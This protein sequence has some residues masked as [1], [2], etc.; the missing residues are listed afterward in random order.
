MPWGKPGTNLTRPFDA[1]GSSLRLGWDQGV[2]LG[3]GLHRPPHQCGSRGGGMHTSYV[4]TLQA[5]GPR[6][7]MNFWRLRLAV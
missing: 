4:S 7:E 2:K 3:Q 5:Q 1:G 6:K